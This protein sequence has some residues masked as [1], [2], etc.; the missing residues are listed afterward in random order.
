MTPKI[1]SAS[2]GRRGP[3]SGTGSNFTSVV[4]ACRLLISWLRVVVETIRGALF[5]RDEVNRRWYAAEAALALVKVSN[6]G[7]QVAAAEVGPQRV[8]EAE[9]GVGRFPQ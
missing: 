7:L 2:P 3:R 5:G 1:S 8:D 4:V 9:L 6:R